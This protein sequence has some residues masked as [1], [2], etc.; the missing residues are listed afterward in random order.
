MNSATHTRR[1]R[2]FARTLLGVTLG[3]L[4]PLTSVAQ[5]ITLA[6]PH[7]NITLTDFGYSDFLLDN[8][9]GFEGREYLS[10]EW[11]AAVA[12]QVSGQAAVPPR[13]L[14]PN[15]MYP[16]WL[17]GSP[18]HVVTSF[19]A[20]P[21]LNAD[22]LPIAESVIANSDLEVTLR[23]EM[24]DTVVGTPMG[25]TPASAGGT[26]SSISS[27]RYVMKQTVTVR[28]ISGAAI[29]NLQLFQ[30]LH[31][32]QSERGVYDNR[33]HTGPLAEFR[34]DTTLAGVDAWAVGAGSSPAGLEDFIGFHASAV[35]SA[36]E[37]GHYGIEGNGVDDH[38]SAKPSDG[39]HLSVENNWT[40]APYSTREGTDSFTP[41]QRWVAGAERWDL[42]TLS[43]GASVSLDVLLSVRTGTR[44]ISG[45]SVVGGCNGG[46][47]VPGGVDYEFEDV[48]SEGSCFGEYAQADDD[49]LAVRVAEGEFTALDFPQPAKPAQLWKLQFTG[50]SPVRFT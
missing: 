31:G 44:V 3:L 6:N 49:E 20:T 36:F 27:S 1:I 24:L 47:T 41:A 10:G 12:Y 17:T 43:V 38:W 32:L 33:A 42:G 21:G 40:T 9:P 7:W 48:S 2:S 13:W 37:I 4:S 8:T 28:N 11:G 29:S 5:G 16:D 15:F 35:P 18:F 45:T 19:P 34:Y 22:G 30:F 23:Y 50:A 25:T 26:G 46:S 39:V 14:Q